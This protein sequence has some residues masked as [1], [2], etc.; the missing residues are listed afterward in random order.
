MIKQLTAKID[1]RNMDNNEIVE[2]ILE[3]RKIDNITH[4][5]N[6]NVEDMFPLN[7][8]KGVDEACD[9]I[10]NYVDANGKFLVYFDVDSD[11]VGSGAI[12]TR[13][14][15]TM[16][17]NVDTYIG[18]G[19]A[20]GLKS[21]PLDKLDGIDV[22][23]IVDSIDTDPRL[24]ERILDK[25]II[26]IVL[27]HHII[28]QSLIDANVDITLVSC[29][30]DYPNT[31]LSGSAVTWKTV[32]Y[33]DYIN[34]TDYAKDLVDLAAT[35][36]VA[37]MM[38]LSIP[39][40]RYICYAGFNNLKNPAIKKII[41]SYEFNSESIS[42]SIAPLINA[43]MRTNTNDIAMQMFITD[44]DDKLSDLINIAK[45]A[46]DEQKDMV[47][48]I[49]DSLLEQG[50]SQQEMKC[51]VFWIPEEY[52][53]ITGLLANK[54]LEVYNTPVLVVHPND[55]NDLITGSMR[56]KGIEDFS[57][58]INETHLAAAYGHE[59]SAGIECDVDSFNQFITVINEKLKDIEFETKIEADI[60]LTPSQINTTLIKQLNAINRISGTGCPAI[61]VLIKTNDYEVSTFSSKKHLKIIDK[62]GLL[63][64]KWNT[65]DWQTMSNTKEFIGVG[66]LSNPWY[67]RNTYMQ[68]TLDEYTQQND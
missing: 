33:L 65:N 63:L 40:N 9:I 52:Q 15:R 17:A 4:F 38:N 20:H 47:D 30:N 58:M 45:D 14:L 41:G 2:S 48:S 25:D 24:Y 19:K 31:S 5:L 6:P 26:I 29:M 8:L 3:N 1:G 42:F 66:T 32:S 61:K 57:A 34:C 10:N 59:N 54:L 43:C 53:G 64:V 49:L 55:D 46:K 13:Y 36:L 23:I 16:G 18:Y 51:K 44:D 60:E 67:G 62:T 22:L 12:M 37:D 50:D 11:G 28:P 21:L 56:A 35:G 27:D 68:L 39:E 7:A